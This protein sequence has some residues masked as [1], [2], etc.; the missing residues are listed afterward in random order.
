MEILRDNV[1]YSPI[2][3]GLRSFSSKMYPFMPYKLSR[4]VE[5][6]FTYTRVLLLL[7]RYRCLLS[8]Y[9]HPD[10]EGILL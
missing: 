9:F 3:P 6:V 10:D 5:E 7:L 1:A 8:R 2:V 4:E